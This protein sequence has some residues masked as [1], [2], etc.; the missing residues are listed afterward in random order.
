VLAED[1]QVNIAD[2]GL[3]GAA[4]AAA[5]PLDGGHPADQRPDLGIA[6]L[7]IAQPGLQEP[8][9]AVADQAW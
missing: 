5:G 3:F 4:G 8:V 7:L 9:L 6:Q 2:Q 1:A